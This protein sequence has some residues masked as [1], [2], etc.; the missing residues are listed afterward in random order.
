MLL[1]KKMTVLVGLSI[2]VVTLSGCSKAQLAASAGPLCKN[3]AAAAAKAYSGATTKTGQAVAEKAVNAAILAGETL[4]NLVSNGHSDNAAKI[5]DILTRLRARKT[6]SD[7]T[8]KSV[9]ALHSQRVKVAS[10]LTD[11]GSLCASLAGT[12]A[13]GSQ[14]TRQVTPSKAKTA[15]A[16]TEPTP[17]KT[18][19]KGKG[20]K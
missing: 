9:S 18:T 7:L 13:K 3:S 10:T 20:K 11:L 1:H 8:G 4:A 2:A 14:P 5:H 19:S 17:K 12:V 16:K 15:K 6:A